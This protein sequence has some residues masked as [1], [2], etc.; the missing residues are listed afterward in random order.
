MDDDLPGAGLRTGRATATVRVD[1]FEL[2]VRFRE[3][4]LDDFPAVAFFLVADFFLVTFFPVSFRLDDV[5]PD[6]LAF[7]LAVIRLAEGL[8]E[9][10]LLEAAFFF[11]IR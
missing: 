4:F 1:F 6:C 11:G 8:F 2:V 9:V 5:L 10:D 7:L 3:D